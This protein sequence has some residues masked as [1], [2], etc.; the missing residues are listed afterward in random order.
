MGERRGEVVDVA[1]D[2][3][4]SC[5]KPGGTRPMELEVTEKRSGYLEL[6]TVG[7][8]NKAFVFFGVMMGVAALMALGSA[9]HRV[10]YT[11]ELVCEREEGAGACTLRESS[12]W[13]TS[14]SASPVDAIG[15]VTYRSA[16]DPPE[17]RVLTRGDNLRLHLEGEGRNRES[18]VGKVEAFLAG[19]RERAR[20]T[21]AYRARWG[22]PVVAMTLFALVGV[23]LF[24][25]MAWE[26][27]TV[28]PDRVEIEREGLFDRERVAYPSEAIEK[29]Q[30]ESTRRESRMVSV[31]VHRVIL[32]TGEA[33][34]PLTRSYH[35]SKESAEKAEREVAEMLNVDGS[36]A[37]QGSAGTLA[38]DE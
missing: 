9:V 1:R 29:V 7:E 26:T 24:S 25:R 11:E 20:V 6:R 10:T 2:N 31:K 28:T 13:R 33:F 15:S 19:D 4:T 27:I 12:V 34:V 32:R 22:G 23:F 8:R 30:V 14:E 18:A 5:E 37:E 21:R 38:G 36:K 3:E 16:S 17:L 35:R